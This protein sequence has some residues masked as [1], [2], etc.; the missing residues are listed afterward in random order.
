MD[1][2]IILC[3]I[4]PYCFCAISSSFGNPYI[5]GG[6]C[7]LHPSPSSAENEFESYLPSFSSKVVK[8]HYNK[9]SHS[10]EWETHNS[11]RFIAML[12]RQWE[13]LLPSKWEDSF[14]NICLYSLGGN[15]FH[16]SNLSNLI[17]LWGP[18]LPSGRFFPL[19]YFLV[20]ES[21][22]F[23]GDASLTIDFLLAQV[24][25]AKRCLEAQ[26]FVYGYRPPL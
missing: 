21:M 24:S 25:E 12:D 7:R 9:N 1:P 5:Y 19:P 11:H 10:E 6:I 17:A 16:S 22:P 4:F 23:L 14:I 20:L 8:S 26:V 15:L 2:L 18:A 13:A 3:I